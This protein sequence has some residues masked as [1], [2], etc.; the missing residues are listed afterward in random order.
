MRDH[1][2]AVSLI[3]LTALVLCY[4]GGGGMSGA[5]VA[6][7]DSDIWNT[8][9]LTR[10]VADFISRNGSA[11]S[12]NEALGYPHGLNLWPHLGG[13]VWPALLAPLTKSAG[14]IYAHNIGALLALILTALAGYL[15]F[16]EISGDAKPALFSAILFGCGLYGV[17]EIR[18][19]NPELAAFAVVPLSALATVRMFDK[20]G[21]P[22]VILAGAAAAFA[23]SFNPYFGLTAFVFIALASFQA[24]ADN[25]LKST[26]VRALP[27][28]ALGLALS[29]PAAWPILKGMQSPAFSAVAASAVDPATASWDLLEP[30]FF[31]RAYPRTICYLLLV[32]A[33]AGLYKAPKGYR[34]W[35]L[36]ASAFFLLALGPVVLVWGRATGVPGPAALLGLFP[37]GWR[38]RYPYRFAVGF[39]LCLGAAAAITLRRLLEYADERGFPDAFMGRVFVMIAAAATLAVALPNV[40]MRVETPEVYQVLAGESEPGAVLELPVAKGF[41]ENSRRLFYQ[42]LHGRPY[43]GGQPLPD[44]PKVFDRSYFENNTL[45]DVLLKPLEELAVYR[46]KSLPDPGPDVRAMASKGIAF[47]I[48]HKESPGADIVDGLALGAF[49]KPVYADDGAALYRVLPK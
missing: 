25:G 47:A 2:L 29:V 42:S 11:L 1:V 43:I 6:P 21:A 12:A 4:P 32:T 9:W 5:V 31:G 17:E 19:G 39:H 49:G 26:L 15:F 35:L 7:A 8:M 41:Y 33:L 20:G 44:L 40:S 22:T 30:I 28:V 46:F 38:I 34:F 3:G 48:V 27:A 23:F 36:A 10:Q 45:L 14:S 18:F 37:G 24:A 13:V 16:Y